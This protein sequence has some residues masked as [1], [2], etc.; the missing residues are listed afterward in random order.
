LAAE[1]LALAGF[2]SAVVQAGAR[3]GPAPGLGSSASVP[4]PT[5]CRTATNGG[6]RLW[7]RGDYALTPAMQRLE[8]E[9]GSTIK[10][11]NKKISLICVETG[12][13]AD[14]F[15]F[16][17]HRSALPD[18]PATASPQFARIGG[19]MTAAWSSDDKLYLLA[20]HGDEQFLRRY[21]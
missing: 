4:T 19:I 17:V 2:A 13:D 3:S 5:P 18:A 7:A 6:P 16:V 11:H 15:L 8:A 20:G 10:W 1:S 14:L 12:E 9:G 21:L